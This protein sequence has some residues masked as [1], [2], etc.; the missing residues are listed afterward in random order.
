MSR[1]RGWCKSWDDPRFNRG[2]LRNLRA[3]YFTELRMGVK[4]AKIAIQIK[5]EREKTARAR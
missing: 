4:T 3:A 2:E 5:D 1:K